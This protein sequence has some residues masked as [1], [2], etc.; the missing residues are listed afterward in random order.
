MLVRCPGLATV[1]CV[2][3]KQER[4]RWQCKLCQCCIERKKAVGHYVGMGTGLYQGCPIREQPPALGQPNSLLRSSVSTHCCVTLQLQAARHREWVTT[5][6]TCIR[7]QILMLR[8]FYS[9]VKDAP[10][11]KDT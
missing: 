7:A 10:L 8:L 2:F 11:P 1:S 5:S 4:H 6:P 3:P 9:S